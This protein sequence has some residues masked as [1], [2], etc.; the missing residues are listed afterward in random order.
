MPIVNRTEVSHSVR[1][2]TDPDAV[3]GGML[4]YHQFSNYR[5]N[6]CQ[7]SMKMHAML[8]RRTTVAFDI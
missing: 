1:D 7:I 2:R 5:P 6:R 3:G 4:N 8:D